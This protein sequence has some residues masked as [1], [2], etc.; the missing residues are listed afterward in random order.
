MDA[1]NLK[2]FPFYPYLFYFYVN[3]AF[4]EK[5][6]ENTEDQQKKSLSQKDPNANLK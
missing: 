6:R 4:I 1:L 5:E 3:H 2:S